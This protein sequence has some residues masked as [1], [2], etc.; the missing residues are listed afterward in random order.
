MDLQTAEWDASYT[1]GDNCCFF[2]Y[3][4]VVK[5]L[6]RFVRKRIGIETFRE[7][8]PSPADRR[9]RALDFGCG[10]GRTAILF[11]QF[12]IEG[13]GV[14]ISGESLRMAAKLADAMGFSSLK[15]RLRQIDG[16]GPLPYPNGY[17]DLA[18][19]R[20]VLDSMSFEVARQSVRELQRVVR[21]LLYVDLICGDNSEHHR[22]FAGELR[23]ETGIE[24]GTIQSYFNYAKIQELFRGTEFTIRWARLMTEQSMTERYQNSRYYVVLAKDEK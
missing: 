12:G 22:E 8:L 24:L 1:R 14:E 16:T 11:E 5:F 13:H 6:N 10:I 19:A 21:R 23:V 4:E 2:A 18:T 9:L 20:G 15:P 17:F 3:E 7:I